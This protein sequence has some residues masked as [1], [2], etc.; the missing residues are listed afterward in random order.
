M[1]DGSNDRT[2]GPYSGVLVQRTSE[3]SFLMRRARRLR[4]VRRMRRVLV[5]MGVLALLVATAGPASAATYPDPLPDFAHPGT[6][7]DPL[8]SPASGTDSRPLLVIVPDFTDYPASGPDPITTADA[9]GRFFGAGFGSVGDYYRTQSFGRLAFTPAAETEGTANDGVV[10]APLGSVANLQNPDGPLAQQAMQAADPFV[11]FAA[12]DADGNGA[13]DARELA[14]VVLFE[15]DPLSNCGGTRTVPAGQVDGVQMG[16]RQYSFDFGRSN[17]ITHAH[18]LAHQAFGT[19]DQFYIAGPYD[20]TAP[21]CPPVAG[22]QA[23][24]S[25]F[26]FNSWHKLHLDWATPRVVTR[27]GYY[28][29]PEWTPTGSSFLLYD[30]DRGTNDY[31]LVENRRRGGYDQDVADQGLIVWRIDETAFRT[32][33]FDLVR[34]G[35]GQPPNNYGGSSVDAFDACDPSTATVRE[36]SPGWR[37]GTASR[38]AI[39]AIG[40]A[41]PTMRVFFDVRGPGLLVD[42]HRCD[43]ATRPRL[44]PGVPT[45][46]DIAVMN[47]SEAA[48]TF[49]FTIADLPAGW[50]AT[51]VTRTLAA[52][53]RATVAV[54][55]TPAV[56]AAVDTSHTVR[57]TGVS[58]TDATVAS[59]SPLTLR[60]S[61][62]VAITDAAPVV[63]GESGT[64]PADFA[65]TLSSAPAEPVTV[66][67]GTLDGTATQPADYTATETSVAFAPGETQ[68]VFSVPVVGDT[69]DE[70][71][72]T[73]TAR[74]LAAD[75]AAVRGGTATATI[76]DDDRNGV[77]TCRASAARPSSAPVVANPAE[78]PC[79]DD[80]R[81]AATVRGNSDR[82]TV[83][84]GNARASTDVVP[85]DQTATP[86]AGDRGSAAA[87][88]ERMVIDAGAARVTLLATSATASAT[89]TGGGAP[90]LT[91]ASEVRG[92]T[93]N[94][95]T[96]N[97]VT[98]PTT[99][100]VG[101]AFTLRLNQQVV[102]NGKI[103]Q[104][105]MVIDPPVG[106]DIVLAEASAGF[107]G[108]P[109]HPAGHPCTD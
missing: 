95:R 109:A 3:W 59:E 84:G 43:P 48:D 65:V 11:N 62:S 2:P 8:L 6:P 38:V 68:K 23:P 107:A 88:T 89:C 72:E 50:T 86:Q 39:R 66:R 71:A 67:V 106:D 77:F 24:Q 56:D 93:V 105:A 35:G 80:A 81:G 82:V 42:T 61:P 99:I 76:V 31:V 100:R 104:Q 49:R 14:L 15:S 18:E 20:I 85:D 103:T 25:W 45:A 101:N 12:F 96:H 32:R 83:T 41:A 73:F 27:D 5:T 60:T 10:V 52:G 74:I 92:L 40:S 94:G 57:A 13:V 63:E 55:V 36:V 98:A 87:A 28:D 54:D 90:A 79:L 16:N 69:V 64:R 51:T 46:V 34:P 29:V 70:P 108:A 102:V 30:P 78:A 9:V 44:V 75:R 1:Q 53:E 4:N 33:A 17:N 7:H 19:Q 97:L 26:S 22:Q 21:T 47:T 58:T 37:D 91:A